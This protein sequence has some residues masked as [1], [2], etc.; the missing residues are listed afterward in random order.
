MEEVVELVKTKKSATKITVEGKGGALLEYNPPI[1]LLIIL[2][3][4]RRLERIEGLF[5][6]KQGWGPDDIHLLPY[7]AGRQ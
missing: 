3:L 4:V 5:K 2:R 7:N 1:C 6:R